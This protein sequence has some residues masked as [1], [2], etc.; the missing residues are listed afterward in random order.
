VNIGL[1]FNLFDIEAEPFFLLGFVL[2][3]VLAKAFG[4][5]LGAKMNNFDWTRSFRIGT[6]MIP[7]GEVALIVANMALDKNL[8]SSDIL[9]ATIL[10][11]IFSA[12]L[13]PI[14]L[15]ITFTKMGQSSFGK[16]KVI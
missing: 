7:R 3:A 8:I 6:G 2:L 15:K 13:T 4:S 14:L 11:V 12:L 9:S 5:S 16:N 1:G 10:M